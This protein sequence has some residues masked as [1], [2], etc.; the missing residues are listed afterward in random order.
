LSDETDEGHHHD[1]DSLKGTTLK[2]YRLVLKSRVPLGIHDI[3]RGLGLSSPSV[4]QYHIRKLLQMKLVHEEGE[5]YVV[6]KVVFH[7]VIRIRRTAIPSQI[8][9]V[10]FFAASLVVMLTLLR[11]AA[12]TSTYAFALAVTL[13]GLA[14]TSFETAKTFGRL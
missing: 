8:A 13:V 6:E 12:L 11:P 4:A 9:Y 7:N 1:E 3:Q 10:A 14:I 2:V 5:G